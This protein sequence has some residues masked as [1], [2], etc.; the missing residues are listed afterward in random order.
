MSVATSERVDGCATLVRLQR[1]TATDSVRRPGAAAAQRGL[2]DKQRTEADRRTRSTVSASHC[3]C[4]SMCTRAHCH[5]FI[6]SLR[7]LSPLSTRKD[8]P[9]P[10]RR[11]WPTAPLRKSRNESVH[12]V[13]Q[14]CHHCCHRHRNRNR[15]PQP[16]QQH[17]L[18]H[19]HC[20]HPAPRHTGRPQPLSQAARNSGTKQKKKRRKGETENRCSRSMQSEANHAPNVVNA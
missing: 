4:D 14:S 18:T 2:A 15:A 8:W 12:P 19:A 1:C 6:F 17:I 3:Y 7:T 5:S 9:S 10:R 20:S 11:C 16:A 13:P